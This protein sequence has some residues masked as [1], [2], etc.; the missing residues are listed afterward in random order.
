MEQI[1][2]ADGKGYFYGKRYCLDADQAYDLFRAEYDKRAGR[3]VSKRLASGRNRQE[4]VHGFGFVF[5]PGMEPDGHEFA[6]MPKINSLLLGYAGTISLSRSI[7][8][9]DMP[10]FKDYATYERW[11]DWAFSRGSGAFRLVNT[12]VKHGRTRKHLRKRFR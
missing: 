3:E 6:G 2:K 4:R 10:F 1:T 12:Q 7:G 11:V 5:A 9:W 8:C